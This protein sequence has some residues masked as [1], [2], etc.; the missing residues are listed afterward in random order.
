MI[1]TLVFML[2]AVAAALGSSYGAIYWTTSRHAVAPAEA[3]HYV[4]KKTRV[5]NVPILVDGQ[6]RG[7]VVA[8]FLYTADE[9]AMKEAPTPPDP[10]ILD[11]AFRMIYA[12][13]QRDFR[14]LRKVDLGK[15]TAELKSRVDKRIKPDIVKDIVIEDFNYISKDDIRK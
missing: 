7:Y 3:A 14:D 5:I 6:V 10:V 11:E 15:L 8:Q 2:V 12:D 13:E 9:K 1:R 4:Q